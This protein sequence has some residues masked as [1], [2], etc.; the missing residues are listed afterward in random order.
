MDDELK[1]SEKVK[2]LLLLFFFLILCL[3]KVYFWTK[4]K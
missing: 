3:G 4:N 1:E 2:G